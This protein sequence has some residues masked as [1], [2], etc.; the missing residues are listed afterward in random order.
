V[1]HAQWKTHRA[2]R[3]LGEEPQPSKA[4]KDAG[5]AFDLAQ[6]VYDRRTEL[7]L[8]QSRLARQAGMT[9]AQISRIEQGD[10]PKLPLLRRL[11]GALA[12]RLLI[13]TD[14]DEVSFKLTPRK[15]TH[16]PSDSP[17]PRVSA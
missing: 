8:S 13:E 10:V 9:Q 4:Y 11:A 3:L 15:G 17:H 2:R 16:R 12:V 5:A 6:A 1:N 7:G 14:G